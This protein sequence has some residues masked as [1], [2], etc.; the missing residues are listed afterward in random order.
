MMVEW[1]G[2]ER[3]ARAYGQKQASLSLN[4]TLLVRAAGCGIWEVPNKFHSASETSEKKGILSTLH[5]T[6][7]CRATAG[8]YR[9]QS[10]EYRVTSLGDSDWELWPPG[11]GGVSRSSGW[12][13]A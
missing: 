6:K 9:V 4:T 10:K 11:A 12:E 3:D 2:A 8:Q 13:G 5:D 1:V 7:A